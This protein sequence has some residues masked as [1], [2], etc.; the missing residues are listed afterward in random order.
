MRLIALI[1]SAAL[2]AGCASSGRDFSMAEV[3]ALQPGVSTF[4][5]ATS[6]LGKP[7]LMRKNTDGS[8]TAG[9]SYA[10]KAMLSDA[11]A[12]VVTVLFDREGGIRTF[13]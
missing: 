1:F 9:W 12:K 4:Q 13:V 8:Y 5:D 7:R 3:D 10:E 11:K 6:K 2:M